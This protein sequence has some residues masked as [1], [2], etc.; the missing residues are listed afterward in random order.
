[1]SVKCE[2]NKN[3]IDNTIGNKI[4]KVLGKKLKQM[5]METIQTPVLLRSIKILWR[6]NEALLSHRR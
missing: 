2:V 1:M 3:T 5:D 6:V 4:L